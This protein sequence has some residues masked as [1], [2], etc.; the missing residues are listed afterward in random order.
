[1]IPFNLNN[2]ISNAY[3]ID[4]DPGYFVFKNLLYFS[5]TEGKAA[6]ITCNR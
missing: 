2:V 4:I 5:K 3:G 6:T 1:M